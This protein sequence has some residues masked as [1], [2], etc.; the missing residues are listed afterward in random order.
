MAITGCVGDS[1]DYNNII[2]YSSP[3]LK[4]TLDAKEVDH[5]KLIK[6]EKIDVRTKELIDS[7]FTYDSIIFSLSSAA[8]VNWIGLKQASDSGLITF[9]YDI[10]TKDDATYSL[11]DSTSLT[12][13][14]ATGIGTVSSRLSSGRIL[15]ELVNSKTTVV[16]VEAVTDNR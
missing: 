12:I 4:T 3:I 6:N 5:A 9:P 13:F 7:G 16:D 8:Q 2:W 1:S 14:Y 15:K 10:T 11:P